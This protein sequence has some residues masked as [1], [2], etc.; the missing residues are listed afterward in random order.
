[1]ARPGSLCQRIGVD[2][3]HAA[4]PD[5]MERL[6][7]Q[8]GLRSIGALAYPACRTIAGAGWNFDKEHSWLLA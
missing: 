7:L 4:C 6:D 2:P 1:M 8:H 3:V 5:H